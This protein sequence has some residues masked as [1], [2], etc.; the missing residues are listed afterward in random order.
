MNP[1]LALAAYFGIVLLLVVGGYSLFLWFVI[2]IAKGGA[3]LGLATVA[4]AAGIS[5]F[6]N[7]CSFPLLPVFLAKYFSK[8]RDKQINVISAGLGAALGVTIF[9]LI[10]GSIIGLGGAA[11][12][13]SFS[14]GSASPNTAVL[15][16]RAIIGGLLVFLGLSHLTGR[17]LDLHSVEHKVSGYLGARSR[18]GRVGIVS[19]GFLYPLLGI[20]CG[21]PI[22]TALVVFSLASG[23]FISALSAFTIYAAIMAILMIIVAA[24]VAS[25]KNT[26]ISQLGASTQ[27]IKKVSGVILVV[28]GVF[29]LSSSLLVTQYTQLFLP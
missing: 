22:L 11:I 6:F 9:N 20:G 7:P 10:L 4:V 3:T 19:Y 12:G 21:G 28:V 25:A 27:A 16:F 13:A 23:G 2:N 18:T 29:L 14:I 5:S 26:L 15:T 24:L 17:W 8:E 1:K